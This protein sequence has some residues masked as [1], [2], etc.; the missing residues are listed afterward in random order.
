[1]EKLK[2]NIQKFASGI[3]EMS[4]SGYLQGRIV[5]SSVSKGIVLNSSD[6]TGTVQI[7]R[8][9][10]ATTTGTFNGAFNIDG[11][12]RQISWYGSI[13]NEWVSIYSFTKN[14]AHKE[15][16]TGTCYLEAYVNGPSGTSLSGNITTNKETVT[17]DKI[18][19]Y[20]TFINTPNF[21]DEENPV[22]T[23]SNPAGD[24]VQKLQI[25][26]SL[27]G[28]IDDI[29]Y[30]EISKNQT[31]YTFELTED[32]RNILR[33]ST[34]S[35]NSKI[36]Q[37]LLKT[38]IS[39]TDFIQKS[40]K[41]LTIVNANPTFSNFE[42]D[43]VNTTTLALTGNAKYNINGYSTIK[44]KISTTNKASANK[45]A[46]MSKYRFTIGD[47]SKDIN[48]SSTAEVSGSIEKAPVGTY[49]LYAIDSRNNS[50]LVTKLAQKVIEYSPLY[51][52]R[53][54]TYVSRDDGGVGGDVALTFSGYIWNNSFGAKNNSIKSASYRFKK[55]TSSEW[56]TGTTNITPTISGN[57]FS[58][59]A[60]VRSNNA[61]Y[62]FDLSSSYD[63]E[64]TIADQLSSDTFKLT[65]LGSAIPNLALADTGV[66]IMGAY[67]ESVGGLLQVGGQRIDY[68]TGIYSEEEQLIGTYLGKPLYRKCF[69][70][71]RIG[72]T[73][74]NKTHTLSGNYK[75]AIKCD[76]LM[77]NSTGVT[78]SLPLFRSD[79]L[80]GF[81]NATCQGDGK[82]DINLYRNSAS[83]WLD[84]EL[85]AIVE[86]TKTT[87]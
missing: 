29:P 5:W 15:D 57:K 13:S 83:S 4:T 62:T 33:N 73:S 52:D 50:T 46:T 48:Y 17:L 54:N 58:F 43:D 44:A 87:D 23:Y 77:K 47:L 32:E 14:V 1:M 28:E 9:N 79:G 31:S 30:R 85:V 55:T 80:F 42:F 60:L 2:L 61:D 35:S 81:C 74:A 71:G 63:F 65:P 72:D 37:F 3:V 56:I 12:I 27:N 84:F 18:N 22:V 68:N 64:I 51:I 45:G 16:G 49:N 82:M 70:L 34:P 75:E 19:R 7:R 59:S 11:D 78:V 36:I 8:T 66:G 6:V 67:D 21:N 20:A 76:A 40:A 41:T 86:Y 39:D 38:T 25:A 10:N 24:N 53:Q 69:K 26:I